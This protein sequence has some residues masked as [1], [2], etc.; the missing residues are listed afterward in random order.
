MSDSERLL[1]LVESSIV[2]HGGDL[3]GWT[4]RSDHTLQLFDGRVTLRAHLLDLGPSASEGTVHVHIF[5]T[6]HEHDDEVLDACLIGIGKDRAAALE[7]AAVLWMTGVAGPI[8]SFLD[9]HPVCMTSQVGVAGAG[10][11]GHAPGNYGLS[12]GLRAF[13]GPSIARGFGDGQIPAALDDTKPWFRFASESA[14]PRR[15][16]IAKAVLASKGKNGWSL[17]LEVD[18]HD[19]SYLDPDWPGGVRAPVAAYL[20]RFVVFEFPRNSTQIPRRA[21][22]ER[23]I[24]HFAENFAKFASVDDLVEAMVSQGFDPDLVQETETISTIAFGRTLFEGHGIQYPSTIIRV[25]RDGRVESD[26]PLMSLPAYTRARALANQLRETMPA[27]DFQS[28]CLCS[29]E[30]NAI[31]KAFEG[32]RDL[33]KSKMYPSLVPDRGVSEQTMNAALARLHEMVVQDRSFRKKPWWKFW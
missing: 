22:L 24:R 18:G 20:T 1:E 5:T 28:L 7:Q 4:R 2:K 15:V 25:R 9:N 6:L 12:S 16:H 3:G 19:V 29:S 14:A 30:S 32:K 10:S 11:M 33:T 8:K 21:E 23:T 13:V 31:L 17:T 26:V 27:N